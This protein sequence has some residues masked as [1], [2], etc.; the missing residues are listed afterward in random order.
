[1]TLKQ[2]CRDLLDYSR[3]NSKKGPKSILTCDE[4]KLLLQYED[5]WD[6]PAGLRLAPETCFLLGAGLFYGY[7]KAEN[8]SRVRLG[9]SQDMKSLKGILVH[10]NLALL[11]FRLPK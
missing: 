4:T 9:V 1:M 11:I 7:V 6:E 8:I 3:H 10:P 2:H 5:S